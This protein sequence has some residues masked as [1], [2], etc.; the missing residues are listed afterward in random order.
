MTQ[1]QLCEK[2]GMKQGSLSELENNE[3][4]GTTMI[5]TFAAVLGVNALWLETG[6]GQKRPRL[7]DFSDAAELLLLYGKSTEAGRQQ[8]IAAAKVSEK[9]I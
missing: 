4:A 9:I 5:A 7:P 1:E 8:I 6:K 3:S 2:V